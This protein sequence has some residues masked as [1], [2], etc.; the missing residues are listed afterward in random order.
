MKLVCSQ[1]DLN[2]NLSLV[3]RAVPSRPTHPVLA[4]ILLS[5]DEKTQKVLLRAF[6]LSLGIQTSFSAQVSVG[7]TITL[8]AK[9]L[10]DIVS[11]LSEGEIE[12]VDEGGDEGENSGIV[13]LIATSG[14]Y[15]FRTMDAEDFPDLPQIGEQG[16]A[17]TLLLPA[18]ILTEGLRATLFAAS[19]EET[20]Q[21]LTGIHLAC[22]ETELEFAATDGHRLAVVSLDTADVAEEEREEE[23]EEKE[24]P[25][26]NSSESP[27]EVTIPAKALR[28]LAAL[29]STWEGADIVELNFDDSQVAFELGGKDNNGIQA[30]RLTSRKLEGAYP[31]YERLIPDD[32]TLSAIVDRRLL[33]AGVE[34]VAVLTDSKNHVVKFSLNSDKSE[35]E[36]SVDTIDVGKAREFIEMQISGESIE[37]AFNVKY[38][39]DGLKALPTSNIMMQMNE[40]KQ[41]VIFTPLGGV[42]MTYLVMPVQLRD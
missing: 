22:N 14:R 24:T 32:F 19:T 6:D 23:G 1:S 42:K 30:R 31:A 35:L 12:I 25:P 15:Q 38:L 3:S 10:G 2:A 4:H 37:V 7:G 33:I 8:P 11:R 34:R 39:M 17:E 28:E 41:P 5:A 20:K 36:L 18:K 40:P 21:V 29:L 26:V 9:L 16:D 13:A 27:V